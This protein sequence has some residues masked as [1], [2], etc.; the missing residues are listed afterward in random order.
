MRDKLVY[1]LGAVAAAILVRNLH[2]MFIALPDEVLQGAGNARARRALL[3]VATP[4][5]VI[6]CKTFLQ[7]AWL[8]TFS[9]SSD[10]LVSNESDLWA[11]DVSRTYYTTVI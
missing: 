6:L 5:L 3:P 2:E 1:V 4:C 8:P 9:S 7:P 11:V 10:Y